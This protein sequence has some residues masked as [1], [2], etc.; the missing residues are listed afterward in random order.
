MEKRLLDKKYYNLQYLGSKRGHWLLRHPKS[1]L[2]IF[3][4]FIIAVIYLFYG[5]PSWQIKKVKISGDYNFSAAEL[6][7]LTLRQM[8]ARWLLFF[9][10]DKLWGFDKNAYQKRL[11]ERWIFSKLEVSKSMPDTLILKVIEQKP[12]FILKINDK[13]IGIDSAGILSNFLIPNTNQSAIELQLE[14]LP[15]N[16]SLGQNIV[17]KADIS[18]LNQFTEAI[19]GQKEKKLTIQ[20]I[21]IKNSPDRTAVIKLIGEREIKVDRSSS[22]QRQIDALILAY[23]E[24]IKNKNFQ[25]IDVTVPSRVYYK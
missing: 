9:K 11:K 13:I 10:Q 3:V 8:K 23:S 19:T 12:N 24:K 20:S 5:L 2:A 15:E 1:V 25:Y 4:F 14:T 16:I 6:K 17:S 22:V 21:L 18:F 7:D